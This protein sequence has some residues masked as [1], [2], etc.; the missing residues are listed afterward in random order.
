MMP[1]IGGVG[2]YE[3]VFVMAPEQ[4]RRFIFITGGASNPAAQRFLD[5]LTLPW[6]E[7]P[8]DFRQLRAVIARLSTQTPLA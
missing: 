2:L 5:G 4:A 6:F 7:K 1:G 3:R 8:C